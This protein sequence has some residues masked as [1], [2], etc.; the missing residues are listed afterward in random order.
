MPLNESF[1]SSSTKSGSST[2]LKPVN[3]NIPSSS[4]S[5]NSV[6]KSANNISPV[7]PVNVTSPKNDDEARW[8]EEENKIFDKVAESFYQRAGQKSGSSSIDRLSKK[9]NVRYSFPKN[10]SEVY[11]TSVHENAPNLMFIQSKDPTILQIVADTIVKVEKDHLKEDFLKEAPAKNDIVFA[12]YDD[13]YH[14]AR[15]IEVEDNIGKVFYIDYGN[16]DKSDWHTFK[17]VSSEDLRKTNGHIFKVMLIDLT[18]DKE[19][20]AKIY[21]YLN[22][23]TFTTPLI[24]SYEEDEQTNTKYKNVYLKLKESGEDLVDVVNRAIRGKTA[25]IGGEK[26]E[27]ANESYEPVKFTDVSGN[28][29]I[30][31]LHISKSSPL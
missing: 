4:T 18:F 19:D 26:K 17:H 31:K 2:I 9:I 20:C 1:S 30:T 6:L 10:N 23:N 27:T 21:E 8:N 5:P 24:V 28:I 12:K 13:G 29:F 22:A 3:N 14:R 11:I 15:V 16:V 7:K 25:K